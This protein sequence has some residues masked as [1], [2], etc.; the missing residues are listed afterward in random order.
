MEELGQTLDLEEFCD[1]AGRLYSVSQ[2]LTIS[3][4]HS[5]RK[6]YTNINER[7]MGSRKEK[8]WRSILL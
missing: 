3:D 1:A 5:S 8:E 2:K 7:K 4:S 6:K